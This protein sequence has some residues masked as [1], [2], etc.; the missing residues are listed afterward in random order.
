[1][2]WPTTPVS[3]TSMDAGTDTPPRADIL[4]M[5]QKVNQM[6]AMPPQESGRLIGVQVFDAPGSYTYTPTNG[7]N[8]VRVQCQAGGGAG[9]GCDAAGAGQSAVSTGGF[10]GAY[11]DIIIS[12]LFSGATV[13]VGSGGAGVSGSNGGAGGNSE[14]TT[15][16]V[17]RRAFGGSGGQKGVASST[18]PKI[19]QAGTDYAGLFILGSFQWVS[20]NLGSPGGDGVSLS[21][22]ISGPGCG[23]A[24]AMGTA[25][26]QKWYSSGSGGGSQGFGSGGSGCCVSPSNP[27]RAGDAGQSG[28]VI[29]WEYA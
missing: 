1:M 2:T 14:F 18:F 16:V 29:V 20:A 11:F 23:G 24:S 27:A 17:T 10:A 25:A 19:T 8:K 13:I 22:L 26:T 3:T 12:S 4:D 7:T 15:G 5:A 6:I 28:I 21:S 9:G